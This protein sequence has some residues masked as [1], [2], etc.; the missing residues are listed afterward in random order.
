MDTPLLHKRA[1][2]TGGT[3]GIGR[4]I[5]EALLASGAMVTICGRT[6]ESTAA[7][8]AELAGAGAEP[9][10]FGIAADVTDAADIDRLFDFAEASMGGVDILIANAGIGIFQPAGEMS[11]ADWKRTIEINLTGAFLCSRRALQSMRRAGSGFIVHISSLAAKNP[12]AGGAAYNASKFG[13]N[14]MSEAMMLDHRQEGIR[15]TTIMPGSVDTDFSPRSA[16]KPSEWKIAASDVATMVIAVLSM[17]ERTLVSRVE[18]RPS[19][20]PQSKG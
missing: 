18:I 8:V 13:L 11:I 5:A 17:P 12:F 16:G 4:A 20:P 1:V 7:A 2:I 3:R 14:G 6:S 9:R 10:A 15:V 19:R